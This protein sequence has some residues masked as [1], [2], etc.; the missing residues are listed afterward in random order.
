[1]A[2]STGVS[3]LSAG[4]SGLKSSIRTFLEMKSGT[5]YVNEV[6]GATATSLIGGTNVQTAVGQVNATLGTYHVINNPSSGDVLRVISNT[7]VMPE[8]ASSE[9]TKDVSVAFW[10]KADTDGGF[11]GSFVDNKFMLFGTGGSQSFSWTGIGVASNNQ[12]VV[13]DATYYHPTTWYVD[14]T[15][16]FY[17]FNF[18][19]NTGTTYCTVTCYIDGVLKAN[20]YTNKW[21]DTWDYWLF[22]SSIFPTLN[23]VDFETGGMDNLSIQDRLLTLSEVQYLYNSGVGLN[24]SSIV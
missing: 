17:V 5:H 18:Q 4:G 10:L 3:L 2:F 11:G 15:W 13:L 24:Y 21:F 1:M 9:V 14:K 19:Y 8:F 23:I 16:R 20:S 12:L 6:T 22:S 7:Q